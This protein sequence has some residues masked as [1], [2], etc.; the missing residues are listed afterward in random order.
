MRELGIVALASAAVDD[1]HVSLEHAF[2]TYL[3]REKTSVIPIEFT[4]RRSDA[5]NI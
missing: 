3:L 2:A 5:L 1:E 4:T